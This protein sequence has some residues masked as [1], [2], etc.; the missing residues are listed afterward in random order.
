[1]LHRNHHLTKRVLRATLLILLWAVASVPVVSA[2]EGETRSADTSAGE[3][4]KATPPASPS[5]W[6]GKLPAPSA[7]A[8]LVSE[9]PAPSPSQVAT[10]SQQPGGQSVSAPVVQAPSANT[11]P[12]GVQP[13]QTAQPPTPGAVTPPQ[14]GQPT[15]GSGS[16]VA[17]GQAPLPAPPPAADTQPPSSQPQGQT[18]QATQGQTPP[19]GSG[20][21]IPA[22]AG[23]RQPGRESVP[24]AA[25]AEVPLA[26]PQVA[27]DFR[28]AP[29]PF[30]VLE[31]V[32]VQM[33]DQRPLTLR[34]AIEMA[35]SNNKDIEVARQ[36]VRVAEFDLQSARGVYDPRLTT[37]SYYD[38][39]ETPSASFLS[40][41][42]S[43]AVTQSGFFNTATFQGL[44]PVAGGGY[45]VDFSSSRVTTNNLFA[46]LNPQ[47]PS[48]L[49]FSY[50]Q[51]L[52]RG[53]SFDQNRRVIEIAKRNLSITDA[54]FRQR[55]IETITNVQRAY[56][57]LVFTLRN[58]QIQRDAVR[59]ARTQLEHNRR[60]VEEGMLAPI[61]VVA[62]EAQVSGFEQSVYS[63]LDDV[64]RAENA[65]KNL[66]AQKSQEMEAKRDAQTAT[67]GRTFSGTPTRPTPSPS[68]RA[69]RP[70]SSGASTGPCTSSS[71][72]R[73]PAAPRASCLRP[74]R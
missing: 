15:Q 72:C 17:P 18:I 27:T 50:T 60:L 64:G 62:A 20:E 39:T 3:T 2:Q 42:A 5:Q 31:R 32:G 7:T 44:T 41:T 29:A 53:R 61:D 34:E 51:P 6:G 11:P 8:T 48:A 66:I 71:A 38:K 14:T 16:A 25:P 35:L 67:L 12:Q 68:S 73:P 69:T 47:Y 9:A 40:G 46:S 28:S 58:L 37:F 1:M 30:P 13:P 43:G 49:T 63:A 70:R 24:T 36:N 10:A 23:V 54:Q 22:P 56:W 19:T 4:K 55:A 33:G 45:R 74:W 65:L 59:D 21:Q 57:D 52:L 26:V